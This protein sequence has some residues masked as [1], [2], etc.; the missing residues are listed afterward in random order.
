MAGAPP[1][2]CCDQVPYI[3]RREEPFHRRLPTSLEVPCELTPLLNSASSAAN[4]VSNKFSL[5]LAGARARQLPVSP[6]VLLIEKSV[7]AALPR[8]VCS[9]LVNEKPKLLF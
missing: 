7:H 6:D 8:H 5:G 3:L 4:N 2:E 9:K 1:S